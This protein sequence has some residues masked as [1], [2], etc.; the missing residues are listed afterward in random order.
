MPAGLDVEHPDNL[1]AGHRDDR[2]G[3]STAELRGAPDASTVMNADM[4]GDAGGSQPHG[5]IQPYLAVNFCIVLSGIF[6][7]RS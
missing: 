5:N 6:P 3:G 4:L 7:S 1:A 2:P